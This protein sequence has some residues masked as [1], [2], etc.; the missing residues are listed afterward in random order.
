MI[1]FSS[2]A[3][4]D[5]HCSIQPGISYLRSMVAVRR[6]PSGAPVS[7]IPGLLTCVQLPPISFS[8]GL[9]VAPT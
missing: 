7:W 1:G 8:S 4:Q 6:A 3:F 5:E 2:P 9:V